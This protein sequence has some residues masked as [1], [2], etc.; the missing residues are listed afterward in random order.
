MVWI[1]SWWQKH[2]KNFQS[3]FCGFVELVEYAVEVFWFSKY[4]RKRR[5]EYFALFQ[6]SEIISSFCYTPRSKDSSPNASCIIYVPPL[7]TAFKGNRKS[8]WNIVENWKF[9]FSLWFFFHVF[10]ARC[11]REGIMWKCTCDVYRGRRYSA[12]VRIQIVIFWIITQ[13]TQY[14]VGNSLPV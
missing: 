14:R 4:R 11:H 5:I 9:R 13:A 1:A 10:F 7:V 3:E 2:E 8:Y 6:K 12:Y